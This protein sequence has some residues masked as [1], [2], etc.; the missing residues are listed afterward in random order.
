MSQHTSHSICCLGNRPVSQSVYPPIRE[1]VGESVGFNHVFCGCISGVPID[2]PW[3][4]EVYVFVPTVCFLEFIP[5]ECMDHENP[6]TLFMEQ[7]N[8]PKSHWQSI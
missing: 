3:T 7:V 4:D 6:S 8:T 5:V 1:P 2:D